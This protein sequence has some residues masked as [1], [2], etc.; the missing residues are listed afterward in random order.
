VG[1]CVPALFPDIL[2]FIL[3]ALVVAGAQL[4]YATVGF[5][6][7]MVTVALLAMLLPDLAGAVVTLL[8]LTAITE[9]WV[10]AQAWREARLRLLL[11]LLPTTAIGL[12]AGTELLIAGDVSWLKRLLG[13]VVLG[14]GIWFFRLERVQGRAP[15]SGEQ[16]VDTRAPGAA[17]WWALPAGLAAGAL[18][19]LFGTGGPPVIIFLKRY[20]L[21]K[22]GF[23][24][25][26]LWFFLIMSVLRIT[27]YVRSGL[28]NADAVA[29]AL[30]L[31]PA[32]I[33]GIFAGMLIHRRL[34]EH[35]FAT[36][37][38]VLLMLLGGLL[39]LGANR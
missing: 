22:G 19:G 39:I 21:D 25:T 30:W 15:D 38:S 7:G 26:L 11:G 18:A 32:T 1:V 4:I 35:H 13:V 37:V 9:V 36:A 3:C 5:G 2:A 14:A 27:S 6:A 17:S 12:W 23:R 16:P 31:L 24:A 20:G 33:V 8:L 34:D 29:A 10:L 28:L